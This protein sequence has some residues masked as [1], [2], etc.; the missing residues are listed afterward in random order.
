MNILVIKQTSLGDVLHSTAALKAIKKKYPHAAVTFMTDE[1]SLVI[2]KDNPHI[3]SFII[4]DVKYWEQN[5]YKHPVKVMQNIRKSLSEL[6]QTTYDIAFDLQG[7]ERTV[8]FLYHAKA[9]T[10]YIKGW[11]PFLKGFNNKKLYALTE[12]HNVLK[13]AGIDM[14]GC[15]P[16]IFIPDA[17]K[18]SVDTLYKK[19]NPGNKKL[20]LFSP[21]SSWISKD[22]P[23][24][25]YI[26]LAKK[27]GPAYKVLF[28]GSTDKKEAIDK[29]LT[30]VSLSH[31][32]SIAG[33]TSLLEFAE[34][35]RRCSLLI[36][37]EG[38]SV[39][40]GSVF[41]TPTLVFFGPT[42]EERVGPFGKNSHVLRAGKCKKEP[43]YNR[44][45]R[46]PDCITYFTPDMVYNKSMTLLDGLSD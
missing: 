10:K 21:F 20:V 30:A 1:R 14:T 22:W 26:S 18:A 37:S 33:E 46:N 17:V 13:V 3:D 31:I 25:N 11:F 32:E 42:S 29:A 15:L 45:C 8:F 40:V 41:N 44:K 36:S 38:F 9:K 35:V 4:V 6:K 23:L 24:T 28:T 12:I 5:W 16:E 27:L 43:C 39:H 7:L 2:V 19:Y 34:L